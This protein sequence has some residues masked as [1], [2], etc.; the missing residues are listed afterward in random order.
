MESYSPG[1]LINVWPR[2]EPASVDTFL[3]RMG[4]RGEDKIR[5]QATDDAM[6]GGEVAEGTIRAF[7]EVRAAHYCPVE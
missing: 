3:L 5:V 6:Q 7:V 4:L 1:D 2:P